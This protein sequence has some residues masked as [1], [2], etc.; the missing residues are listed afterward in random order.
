MKKFKVRK[1]FIGSFAI[2][3][4]SS[5]YAVTAEEARQM[6]VG[7]WPTKLPCIRDSNGKMNGYREEAI[8][9]SDKGE[10]VR[11][12]PDPHCRN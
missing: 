4:A 3:V 10:L 7:S 12:V 5:A 11:S 8:G 6:P 1:W 2:L 9:T